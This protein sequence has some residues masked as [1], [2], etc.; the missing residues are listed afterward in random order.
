MDNI[1]S[2]YPCL[3]V[4]FNNLLLLFTSMIAMHFNLVR[5]ICG[6][7]ITDKILFL[8]III[9]GVLEIIL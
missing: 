8:N 6:Q 2:I 1:Y 5:A 7:C 4:I 3:A 9:N